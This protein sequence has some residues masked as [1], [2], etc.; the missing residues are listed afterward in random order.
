M[1]HEISVEWSEGTR[2][3]IS[4]D[5]VSDLLH[6]LDRKFAE[7][8]ALVDIVAATGA[9]LTVGLGAE[10][11]VLSFAESPERQPYY[12]SHGSNGDGDG[13]IWF[14]YYGS[15]TEFPIEQAVPVSD[16]MKAAEE[17][18]RTGSRPST[19]KWESV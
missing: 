8:P 1:S 9:V 7:R 16:A 14:D 2:T 11:S 3:V 15:P 17:F 12:A 19:V 13:T 4:C 6:E 10:A 5:A 18:C